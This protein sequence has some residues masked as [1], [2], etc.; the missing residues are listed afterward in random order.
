MNLLLF[1]VL[2][3][4]VSLAW[5]NK[6][7]RGVDDWTA[8]DVE[9]WFARNVGVRGVTAKVL[10]D[11]GVDGTNALALEPHHLVQLGV[12]DPQKQQKYVT[13]AAKEVA[14]VRSRPADV[15]EFRAVNRRLVD[16][17]LLPMLA[18]TDVGLLWS[19]FFDTDA[20]IERF[21]NEIDEVPLWQF[22][23]TWLVAPALPFWSI[24]RQLHNEHSWVDEV[25]E[26]ALHAQLLLQVASFVVAA[27]NPKTR[28][29]YVANRVLY[30]AASLLSAF[31]LYAIGWV[32]VPL[33]LST[34]VFYAGVY[35]V[36]PGVAL[37]PVLSML[38]A[39]A[40]LVSQRHTAADG[41]AKPATRQTRAPSTATQRRRE[42]SDVRLKAYQVSTCYRGC[43]CT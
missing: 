6:D 33:S 14:R 4:A 9:R 15:F 2:C 38:Y 16:Y 22:W 40:L 35:V 21:D 23:A 30:M 24:S 12:V 13:E 7:H 39:S 5:A 28:V 19:R 27:V 43:S 10:A 25:I 32:V 18:N 11:L 29:A 26:Y 1:H 41:G 3:L 42:A 34:L 36:L 17:W 8:S 31:F 20:V 37:A